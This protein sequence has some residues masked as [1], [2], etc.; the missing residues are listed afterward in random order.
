M[1][2]CR[3]FLLLSVLLSLASA[4]PRA[5]NASPNSTT[6]LP[7]I[8]AKVNV[9]VVDAVVTNGKGE[10]VSGL[11]KKDFEI[12]E[13]GQP[14]TISSFEEHH[15]A[16]LTQNNLPTLPAHVY[17]NYPIVRT[18]D[19]V[20]VLLL[21]ALNT[22][23]RDQ[24]Y[25]H[26][27][28]ITYLKTIPPG[29]RVA[30]FT[31]SSRLRMLQGVTTDSS[32]LLAVLNGDKTTPQASP[33]LSSSTEKESNQHFVEFMTESRPEP[34][35]SP[36]SM[37]QAA[38]DP[39]NA[40]KQ[41]LADTESFQ[42][43]SRIRI[44]LQ[45]LQQLA[46]YLSGLRSRKNVIWFSG[47]FPL[48]IFP[49][50]DVP[51]PFAPIGRF[52][53]D[54]R[55]TADLLTVSQVAIYPVAAEG[56]A[57]DSSFETNGKEIGEKRG[58]MA[59]QDELLQARAGNSERDSSHIAMEELAKATGGQAFY[60]TNGLN[61]V[62]ARV[63]NNGTRYYSL[64]YSPSNANMDGRYRHIQVRLLNAK[65]SL[66]YRRGYYADDLGSALSTRQKQDSDPLLLLMGRN[67]PDYTQIVYEIRV[68]PSNP[69]PPAN[70][71][72]LGSN[73]ELRG[74][75]I[76]YAVDFA[77]SMQDLK[78]ELTSDGVRHGRI[79]IALVAFDREGKP[80]NFVVTKNDLTLRPDAYA[81]LQQ[82]GLQ[83][84]KEIDV[85]REDVFLRS[86]IYDLQAST[87]GT[88]GIPL[89]SAENLTSKTK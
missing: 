23:V 19:S 49:D 32:E 86:G 54:L 66:A 82:V 80:V 78:L 31:L 2:T 9:V 61:D 29:T 88:L 36:Q 60:N 53:D 81:G 46:R 13:D 1:H 42:T 72:R 58:S 71:A 22:P 37:A 24:A 59:M 4:P 75:F 41:F 27:Q 7:T 51:D 76:R 12:L 67:L 85:P 3:R 38:I 15:G 28:I 55:K 56:L 50:P 65:Y 74:P 69:Q 8:K 25:V 14:Q 87:A 79:E 10:A 70:A 48:T 18:A 11:D 33:V 77:I 83:I 16:P 57:G 43:E 26:S 64:A 30:V 6:N 84:H 89:H 20:N 44:T 39:I 68:I 47:S 5:Q 62:L 21:D 34:A 17:T 63:I 52:H 73:T 40:M 45:A 35:P